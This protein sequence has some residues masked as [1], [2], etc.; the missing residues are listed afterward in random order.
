MIIENNNIEIWRPIKG[1]PYFEMSNFNRMRNKACCWIHKTFEIWRML[2]Y[3]DVLKNKY[4]ISTYGRIMNI[5][6][7]HILAQCPSEK[8]YLM[9]LLRANTPR[10]CKTIKIHRIVASTFCEGQNEI[11]CEVNHIDGN[12]NNNHAYNLEW[13]SHLDNIRHAYKHDLIPILHGE[14]HGNA[15]MSNAFAER[16][17][18]LLIENNMNSAKVYHILINDGFECQLAWVQSIKYKKT[19]KFISDKYFDR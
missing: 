2:E 17:C 13:V 4:A 5:D 12:K 9:V 1:D 6:N 3:K 7:G 15:K 16:I 18:Q 14:D 19:Y 8:G 11:C 10:G